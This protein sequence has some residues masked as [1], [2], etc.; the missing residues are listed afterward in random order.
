MVEVLAIVQHVDRLQYH[1]RRLRR[2]GV[3]CS[4]HQILNFRP[5]ALLPHDPATPQSHRRRRH[6]TRARL[7]VAFGGYSLAGWSNRTA[8]TLRAYAD[9]VDYAQLSADARL[10]ALDKFAGLLHDLPFDE[11]RKTRLEREWIGWLGDMTAPEKTHFAEAIA[12]RELDR[13]LA[14]FGQLPEP[15]RRALVSETLKRLRDTRT[16]LNLGGFSGSAAAESWD[17]SDDLQQ[18]LIQNG[19]QPHYQQSP[20]TA[21]MDFSTFLEQLQQLLGSREALRARPPGPIASEK[22][23]E[24]V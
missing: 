3:L 14:S 24:S 17:L 15:R 9:S 10:R 16:R 8:E 4:R 12:P 18:Q 7:V 21:R 6:L 13:L 22:Y 1:L 11:R 23:S 19:L 20:A 2:S 5:C